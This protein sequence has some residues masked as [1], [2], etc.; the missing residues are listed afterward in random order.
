[1]CV[2]VCVC[3]RWE[4]SRGLSSKVS[5]CTVNSLSVCSPGLSSSL[6]INTI[7][8]VALDGNSRCAF[9]VRH[10]KPENYYY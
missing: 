5:N 3:T 4:R 2:C 7:S 1:M 6:E 8:W 10:V 9:N